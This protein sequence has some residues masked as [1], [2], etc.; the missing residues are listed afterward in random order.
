MKITA[1]EIRNIF[2]NKIKKYEKLHYRDINLDL[3]PDNLTTEDI[4]KILNIMIHKGYTFLAAYLKYKTPEV[5][6]IPIEDVFIS[7]HFKNNPPGKHK[8]KQKENGVLNGIINKVTINGNNILVDGYA[9][10]TLLRRNKEKFIPY[11]VQKSTIKYSPNASWTRQSVRNKLYVEQNGKCYICGKQTTLDI[12]DEKKWAEHATV[13]HIIPLGKGGSNEISNCAIACRLCNHIKGDRILTPE[14]KEE[15]IKLST[16][17][18]G[19]TELPAYDIGKVSKKKGRK[20]K[21]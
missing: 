8:L 16:Y 4:S 14:V 20:K 17:T 7:T 5:K 21:A 1:D 15:I 12:T 9:T 18:Q 2:K 3:L 13:D 11:K 10:Y 19:L 6:L